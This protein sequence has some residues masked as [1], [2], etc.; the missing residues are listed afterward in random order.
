MLMRALS[1]IKTRL[2]EL[3]TSG[4]WELKNFYGNG[5]PGT[6]GQTIQGIKTAQYCHEVKPCLN[7][8]VFDS[9]NTDLDAIRY[10]FTNLTTLSLDLIPAVEPQRYGNGVFHDPN[11]YW[12][13]LPQILKGMVKL[14]RLSLDLHV[15]YSY[16]AQNAQAEVCYTHDDLD[17]LFDFQKT[18]LPQLKSLS[19]KRFRAQE[20]TLI[21]LLQRHRAQLHNL[22]LHYVIRTDHFDEPRRY[23][24]K[25]VDEMRKLGLRSLNLFGVEGFIIS[26]SV[27][28][29]LWPEG[30]SPDCSLRDP[31]N[32]GIRY[33]HNDIIEYV[34]YSYGESP[35]EALNIFTNTH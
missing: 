16:E 8:S 27:A 31:E 13:A 1:S 34:L 6:Y 25:L 7:A 4:Y 9:L 29:E 23:W 24:S 26:S 20:S 17:K 35:L 30:W 28:Q 32:A 3:T 10:V 22:C 12:G 19:L 15:V 14:E 5:G 11:D 33:L 21:S 2:D 18:T